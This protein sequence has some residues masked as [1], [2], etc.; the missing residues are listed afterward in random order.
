MFPPDW[1]VFFRI[2]YQPDGLAITVR[3]PLTDAPPPPG[4]PGRFPHL[5]RHDV[6][7]V[8]LLGPDDHYLELEFGPF[9]HYWFL[10]LEGCRRITGEIG[11]LAHN[12]ARNGRTWEA[13]ALF[14]L[15]S[16]EP[17]AYN[18]ACIFGMNRF[19]GSLAELPGEVPD[20]HQ[21]KHFILLPSLH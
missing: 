20:F 5:W 7:E 13:A 6:V 18:V 16:F 1:R 12:C 15:P 4:A 2:E 8:F 11:P 9:G 3:G 17:Q 14:P 21:L 10:T 19:H